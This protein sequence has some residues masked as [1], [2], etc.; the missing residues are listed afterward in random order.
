MGREDLDGVAARPEG[1]A[2]EIGVVALVLQ[3]DQPLEDVLARD[4][5]AL[6]EARD[7]LRIGLDGADAVDA[8]DRRDDDD[9]VPLEQRPG[10]RMAHPVDLL[11][12][13]RFLLDIGVRARHIGLGL[14]IV[15]VA[16]EIF[17]RVVREEAL[18]LAVELGRQRLVRRQDQR[19]AL[20]V[21][22]DMGHG[23]GLA[24]AGDAEQDLA[25]LAAAH[26]FGQ[27]GDGLGLVAGRPEIGHHLDAPADAA[28]AQHRQP[29]RLERRFFEGERKIVR[30][31]P[32][33]WP[34]AAARYR[35]RVAGRP[36]RPVPKRTEN[37]VT[38]VTGP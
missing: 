30:H 31:G 4:P 9:V 20:H 38:H 24:R 14:V 21:L 3:L 27:F 22:D 6:L 15:V 37:T 11:V 28:L 19:R 29:L 2:V 32:T 23:E 5:V 17:D 8:G 18:H 26:A 10:R 1:A 25:A 16:D 35:Q 7:H 36:V 13:A 12:D 33:I 34:G